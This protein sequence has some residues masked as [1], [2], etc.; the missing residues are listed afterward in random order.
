MSNAGRNQEVVKKFLASKSFDFAAFG[1]W[2]KT[3][4]HYFW[5]G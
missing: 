2:P 4:T 5:D 1:K 3:V